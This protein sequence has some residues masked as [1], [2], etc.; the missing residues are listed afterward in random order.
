[1][2]LDVGIPPDK[3]DDG[4]LESRNRDNA[5]RTWI[6]LRSC[7]TTGML[8]EPVPIKW[9]LKRH[10]I[11]KMQAPPQATGHSKKPHTA[12]GS[13]SHFEVLEAG[14]AEKQRSFTD[15]AEGSWLATPADV[16]PRQAMILV[17]VAC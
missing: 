13:W 9:L 5:C 8:W 14:E 2:R 1:M 11:C 3:P 7:C 12:T 6:S 4:N 16:K 10:P 17:G 15:V